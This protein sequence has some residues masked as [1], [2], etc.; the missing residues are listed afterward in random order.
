MK[1]LKLSVAN[2]GSTEILTREELKKVLGGDTGSG[3]GSQSTLLFS[4]HCSYPADM[5]TWEGI[6]L[7]PQE[8]EYAINSKCAFTG[9]ICNRVYI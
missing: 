1:K 2:L 8:I 3:S 9:G 6:Y 7:T 4:C 5:I